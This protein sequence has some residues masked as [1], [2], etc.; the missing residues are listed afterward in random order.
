[1]NEVSFYNRK[2][3]AIRPNQERMAHARKLL[4]AD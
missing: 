4:S 1:M 3:K 2:S